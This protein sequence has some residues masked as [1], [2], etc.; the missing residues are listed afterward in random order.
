MEERRRRWEERERIW[1]S[2]M[3]AAQAGDGGAYEKLLL[4]LLP[5]T[6]RQ[7]ARRVG[8]PATREDIVQNV[9]VSVHRARHTYRAERPFAPWF[10]AIVRNA[11]IDWL[12]SRGRRA[13][14]EVSFEA[15]TVPDPSPEPA[16]PGAQS[17]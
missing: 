12:R 2:W 17:L 14:R 5:H 8:D 13:G 15:E 11:L 6:R 4:D 1:R 3:I 9:F 7:V 10:Y 16:A